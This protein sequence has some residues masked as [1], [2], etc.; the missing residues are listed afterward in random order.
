MKSSAVIVVLV[1]AFVVGLFL[2]SSLALMLLT[3]VVLHH[4]HLQTLD[5]GSSMSLV[6]LL[7]MFGVANNNTPKK[8]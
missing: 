4:F 2:L 8:N 5:Y 1:V 7:S 3:N 6:A